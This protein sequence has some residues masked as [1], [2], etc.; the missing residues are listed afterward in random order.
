MMIK[1]QSTAKLFQEDTESIFHFV[2]QSSPSYFSV[3]HV[4][5]Q[6][7]IRDFSL[8]MDFKITS[9]KIEK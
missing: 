2:T 4:R 1:E 7:Y 9:H 8:P 5:G 6:A 3:Q